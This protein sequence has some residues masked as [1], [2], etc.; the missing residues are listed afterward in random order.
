[1]PEDDGP[2]RRSSSEAD[3]E[4]DP[5][6]TPVVEATSYRGGLLVGPAHFYVA[7]E[8]G[9]WLPMGW[10]ETSPI[11]Y[12]AANDT[13]TTSWATDTITSW[14]GG[15]VATYTYPTGQLN[16]TA[17]ATTYTGV[18][19]AGLQRRT[20]RSPRPRYDQRVL[21]TGEGLRAGEVVE[22]SAGFDERERQYQEENRRRR[23]VAETSAARARELLTSWLTPEQRAEYE[24]GRGIPVVGSAGTRF[25]LGEGIIGNIS[26]EDEHG[27]ELSRVCVHPDDSVGI[28][29]ADYHLGQLLGLATDEHGYL[30]RA[31]WNGPRLR[32]REDGRLTA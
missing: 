29:T 6:Q 9:R 28:P 25:R 30:R 8:Q 18:W 22:P 23:A 21:Y 5:G 32:Y 1:M 7:D 14:G 31:N 2:E 19:P 20:M 12:S 4:A 17:G 27:F 15:T 3:P 13:W 26:I 11:T 10:A 16:V 24:A